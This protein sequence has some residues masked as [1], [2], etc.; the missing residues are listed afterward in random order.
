MQ[1]LLA[2][3]P[4]VAFFVLNALQERSYRRRGIDPRGTPAVALPLLVLGKAAMVLSWSS[5]PVQAFLANLRMVDGDAL[6]W[7]GVATE[8]LGVGIIALGYRDL[9]DANQ[10]GL[11]RPPL[12]LHAGGTYRLSRN[13]VYLGFHLVSAGAVLYSLNPVVGLLAA[14]SVAVHHAIIRA[15]EAH[16]ERALGAEYRAYRGRV[17]RYL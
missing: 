8:W 15:E 10:I 3:A 12:R 2:I 5:V 13:P 9:G 6:P 4:I 7:L 17:R 16:L 11:A 14:V 1:A